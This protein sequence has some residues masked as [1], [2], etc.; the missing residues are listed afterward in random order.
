MRSN[1]YFQQLA[2]IAP[3]VPY[4]G[5]Q[6]NGTALAALFPSKLTSMEWMET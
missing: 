6:T 5:R 1:M 3:P 2:K 4:P